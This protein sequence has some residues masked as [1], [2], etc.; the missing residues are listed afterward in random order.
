MER[1]HLLAATYQA[2][3]QDLDTCLARL[4]PDARIARIIQTFVAFHAELY[5]RPYLAGDYEL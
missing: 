2:T 5:A 1:L 4:Q 3:S